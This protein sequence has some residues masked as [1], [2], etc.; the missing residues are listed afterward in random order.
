MNQPG[1]LPDVPANAPE[2]LVTLGAYAWV[3]V[4]M[5]VGETGPDSVHDTWPLWAG[6]ALALN[7]ASGRLRNHLRLGRWL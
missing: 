2:H 4:V 5:L 1:P 6:A 7:I 3:F